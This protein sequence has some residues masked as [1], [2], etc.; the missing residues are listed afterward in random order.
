M[1]WV[2]YVGELFTKK[3]VDVLEDLGQNLVLV[4]VCI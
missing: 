4:T 1:Q 3:T 2:Y